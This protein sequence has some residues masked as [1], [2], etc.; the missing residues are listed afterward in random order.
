METWE[1]ERERY[2]Y[3]YI[4]TYIF[5]LGVARNK[6]SHFGNPCKKDYSVL[7][8]HNAVHLRKSHDNEFP[9]IRG[10]CFCPNTNVL[11]DL[12]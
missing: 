4:Y 8:L 7:G 10:P 5:G 3:I 9:Q 1:R 2:I 12:Q 6:G 11:H